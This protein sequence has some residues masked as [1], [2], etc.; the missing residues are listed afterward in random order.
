MT[1]RCCVLAMI[2]AAAC[3]GVLPEPARPP[4]VPVLTAAET[5][6]RIVSLIPA[7]TEMLFAMGD[8]DR[9]VGVSN[10]DR[11]P[12]EVE[13][14]PKVGGLLDPDVEGILALKPDLVIVYATQKELIERLDR[15]RIP[16]LQLR[17]PRAARHHHDDPRR[18]RADRV[19][20]SRRCGCLGHGALAGRDPRCHI[21]AAPANHHA[22]LRPGSDCPCATSM[23]AAATVSCTTCLK[24]PA[25]AMSSATSSVQS[26]QASTEMILT[27]RPEVI[28]ELKYGNS[29]KAVDIPRELEAWNT[30]R[31][32]A[33]GEESPR[34]APRRRRVRRAGP[35][36]RRRHAEARRDAPSRASV[37]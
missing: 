36:R 32:G 17:T 8:G 35:S 31:V 9:I 2:L 30:L 3:L 14:I 26:V 24:S 4:L 6:R 33:G 34:D 37:K 27:R 29:L 7:T 23:R 11:F 18:G 16:L 19:S 1:R 25:D 20:R 5:P 22:G 28:I 12:P 10:Y 13:R 21:V 15:A